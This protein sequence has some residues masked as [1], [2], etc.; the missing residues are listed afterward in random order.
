MMPVMKGNR[1]HRILKRVAGFGAGALVLGYGVTCVVVAQDRSPTTRMT[2]P[3]DGPPVAY[4]LVQTGAPAGRV[5][6]IHGAP[7]NAGSWSSFIDGYG[8]TLGARE[9][10]APDRLG[11]GNS[12]G[13]ESLRLEEH[14]RSLAP[15][16]TPG[17]VLVGHSYGGPV[18]L[19][20]ACEYPDRIGGIV[21]VAGAC[22]A[23]MEDAQWAR[24]VVD[25]LAP[26]VPKPWEVANRELLAL[27]EE[28]DSMRPLLERVR[29]P[30]V[31]VHGTWDPVCPHDGTVSYLES[32]FP[33]ARSVRV[34]SLDRAGHN[35]HLSR[36]EVIAEEIRR[37]LAHAAR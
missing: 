17:A 11:Y 31:V 23:D 36:P 34:R 3:D 13:S 19:R 4:R 33:N 6:L 9:I 7:T 32:S 5:V 14:A 2:S 18:A 27:S 28:N 20:A 15:L 21:L 1:R 25:S 12:G 8:A 29:C 37:L 10:V 22:D 24:R 35:L 26:V 16:I 30:I